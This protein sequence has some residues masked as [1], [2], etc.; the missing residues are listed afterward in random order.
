MSK[1]FVQLAV[2]TP[3]ATEQ[4]KA[5]ASAAIARCRKAL[6]NRPDV[7]SLHD[8]LA[9]N[10]AIL[11]QYKEAEAAFLRAIELA[12]TS[13][14]ICA[15]GELLAKT[16]RH[17][18]AIDLWQKALID[19]SD[20]HAIYNY[21]GL[22][23]Q[24]TGQL[25]LALAAHRQ[26][27]RLSPG[28]AVAYNNIGSL[29]QTQN[30]F[31]EAMQSY[32]HALLAKPEFDLAHLNAGSCLMH[33]GWYDAAMAIF[34]DT[35]KL[36]PALLPAYINLA[37]MQ[38]KLGLLEEALVTCEQIL[39]INPN[40]AEIHSSKLF[41]QSHKAGIDAEGQFR[42]HQAFAQQ[43]EAPWRSSWAQHGNQRDPD[44]Q[45]RIGFVS[46]DLNSHA[47]MNFLEPILEHLRHANT[48]ELVIYCN[49]NINDVVTA[50]LRETMPHWH[51]VQHLSDTVMA[52]QIEDDGI[53]ILIDLSGHTAFNRLP[54]FARKPA[55]LQLT[56]MGYPMTSGL[57]AM[58][59]YL[60]DRYY[61]PPGM[62]DAQFTEKLLRLPASA[63]FMPAQNA[64]AVSIAPCLH[65]G[66]ITFGSFNRPNKISPAVIEHWANLLKAV[67]EA[68]MVLGGMPSDQVCDSL[69]QAFIKEGIASDRLSF[70]LQTKM[71]DYLALH[72]L[73]DVCLDTFPYAGGTTTSHALW[74]GVPTLTM[75]G[76][77]LPGRVGATILGH[78]ELH[79]FIAQNQTEFIQKGIAL[80]SQLD[81]LAALRSGMR[82]RM[83]KSALGQPAL[84][85]AGLD[86]A[87]RQIWQRWC[88]GLPAVS[89]DADP[90]QSSL[91]KRAA[92]MQSLHEV[93]VDTALLLA[94]EH[95]QAN[96]LVEAETLYMAILHK[97]P[98]HAIAN[99][100]MGLLAGQLGYPAEAL[101]Y[102][103][104]AHAAAPAEVEFCVSY[105]QA[106]HRNGKAKDALDVL[107]AAMTR[108]GDNDALRSLHAQIQA[109]SEDEQP[110][111]VEAEH[112]FALYQ[113]G[114]YVEL[115][116]ASR[117]VVTRYPR[118][119]FAWSV[120]GTALQVQGKDAL[121]TLQTAVELAP[122]DA[123]AHGN[124]GN[125]WQAAG[126]HT[127][128]IDSYQQAIMLDTTFS[129]AYCNMASAQQALGLL[130]EAAQS[131]QQALA[132]DPANE[133]AQQQL[134]RL[135]MA[136]ASKVHGLEK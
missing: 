17:T 56:W 136:D 16:N 8:E 43:F 106:L 57:Q 72:R 100:N 2:H 64:P 21:L 32:H 81:H 67:P 66:H 41:V 5:A 104:A 29:L 35:I 69:R 10:L 90:T 129:E 74:M 120:L 47:V 44:R 82:M 99:H 30:R 58:D 116:A 79:D 84:I 123:Q 78:A 4:Q 112:I 27:L 125:A 20:N 87:L 14:T 65:N 127:L 49:N 42:A 133:I 46:A 98:A 22:A 103:A 37:A 50:Q 34:K 109:T 3:S 18:E 77:T 40:L 54:V 122:H 33:L 71:H 76:D 130:A 13:D 113:A 115:E 68:R 89:F 114:Q 24:E 73:V 118:S 39:K 124:L 62:F 110:S 107:T 88:A 45:L 1:S 91:S 61:S 75:T 38:N 135:S 94:I 108:G 19:D 70:Y 85:A 132:I 111:E 6:A 63:P 11:E 102:L 96:R 26:M 126:Q 59:Y 12:P 9:T 31:Q 80:A 117:A 83:S 25:D 101:L 28:N 7:A 60:T 131:Y 53:D 95:H 97:E 15:Y 119:G 51:D 121:G 92:S 48:L 128:A 55:P 86:N 36:N 52:Q 23:Y 134:V 105:T 93:K